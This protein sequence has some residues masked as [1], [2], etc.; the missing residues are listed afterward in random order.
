M[1]IGSPGARRDTC[2]TWQPPSPGEGQGAS[3]ETRRETPGRT[4]DR[5]RGKERTFTATA[6]KPAAEPSVTNRYR[7]EL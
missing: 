1:E 4:A 5:A 6:G 3:R 7:D 2:R